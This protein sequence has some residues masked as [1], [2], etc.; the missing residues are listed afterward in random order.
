MPVTRDD[1]ERR[2]ALSERASELK[3]RN[4]RFCGIKTGRDTTFWKDLKEELELTAKAYDERRTDVL[5]VDNMDPSIAYAEARACVR[6]T[7]AIRNIIDKVDRV[8]DI[9]QKLNEESR[10]LKEE[11]EAIDS[12]ADGSLK[13]R[14]SERGGIV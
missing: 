7:Q 5:L 8:D 1:V 12:K 14:D 3:K 2:H 13:K 10:R 9:V 6:A 4:K 11:I